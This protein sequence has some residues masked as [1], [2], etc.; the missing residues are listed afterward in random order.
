M[1]VRQYGCTANQL[2]LPDL[3]F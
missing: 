3:S 2:A 1:T